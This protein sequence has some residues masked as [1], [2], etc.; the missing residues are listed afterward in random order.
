ML[1]A[2]PLWALGLLDL[3]FAAAAS[4]VLWQI[5]TTRRGRDTRQDTALHTDLSDSLEPDRRRDR[6]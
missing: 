1:T 5:N 3:G 2:D 4:A 6:V